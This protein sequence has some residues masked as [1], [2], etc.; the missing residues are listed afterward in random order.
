MRLTFSMIFFEP[1]RGAQTILEKA[2]GILPNG[3]FLVPLAPAH[4]HIL[5]FSIHVRVRVQPA[6]V[7]LKATGEC[8]LHP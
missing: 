7:L 1:Q 8:L 3:L 6:K 4:E 2:A 5:Y